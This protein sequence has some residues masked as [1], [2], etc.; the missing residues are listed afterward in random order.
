MSL[1]DLAREELN[2]TALADTSDADLRILL[3]VVETAY[4]RIR[5]GR[6]V[7]EHVE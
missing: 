2:K 7:E 4:E 3:N 5:V 1:F 6:V